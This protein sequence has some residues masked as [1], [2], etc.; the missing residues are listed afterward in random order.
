MALTR[1][2]RVRLYFAETEGAA[3]GQRVFDV[4]LQG[5]TVLS[6]FD[7]YTAAGGSDLAVVREFSGIQ[8]LDTLT[9]ELVPVLGEPLISGIEILPDAGPVPPTITSTLLAYGI[10]GENFSYTITA[11]GTEPITYG[12]GSLP[13]GLVFDGTNRISGIPTDAGTNIVMITASN[14]AG[15][16][17]R[18]LVIRIQEAPD[19]DGDGIPDSIDSDDDN[20]GMPD[21]WEMAHGLNPKNASDAFGDADGDGMNNLQEYIAGTDPRDGRSKFSVGGVYPLVNEMVIWF[22]SI[23]GRLYGVEYCSNL[24]DQS[25][26]HVLTN[27]IYSI[28]GGRVEVID[29]AEVKQRFYRLKV[30]QP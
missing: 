19:Y 14:V 17:T 21:Y 23:S 4:K 12:V 26:W 24:L 25:G 8:A 22:D 2:Y 28:S 9:V 30:R 7:I 10:A 20:D 1:V 5:N 3:P 6:G 15:T 29:P 18:E 13:A 11:V 16:D 27:G